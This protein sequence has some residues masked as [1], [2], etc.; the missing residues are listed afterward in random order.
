MD[1]D[2]IPMIWPVSCEA[3]TRSDRVAQAFLPSPEDLAMAQNA[4]RPRNAECL[5]TR[6]I[7]LADTS[8]KSEQQR[9]IP[10]GVSS[11]RYTVVGVFNDDDLT[12]KAIH[13]LYDAGFTVDQVSLVA[14]GTGAA[15]I[16]ASDAEAMRAT[17]GAKRGLAIGGIGG[18][19]IGALIGLGALVVPG[20][21]PVI[22]A[23]WV[24]SLLGGAAAGA[25][26]GGWIG[27]M[28]RLN[29]PEDL[30]KNYAKE[31][32]EGCCLVMVLAERGNRQS[33]AERALT[34]AGAIHVDSYPYEA[35]PGEVPG[36]E[37]VAP[38]PPRKETDQEIHDQMRP[39]M[40]V[41]GSNGGRVGTVKEIRDEDFLVDRERRTDLYVPFSVVQN[42]VMSNQTVVLAV[43]D[44]EVP[45]MGERARPG[46]PP[47]RP[48]WGMPPV[49]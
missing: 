22:T 43:P 1:V 25:A 7:A 12:E 44:Y 42:V 48:G 4:V 49:S 21:G 9:P 20:V 27:S 6:R 35:R 3:F 24:G 8:R 15:D 17:S 2:A 19:V 13:A 40:E 16:I 11:D 5:Q 31:I 41:V 10:A 32:S 26:M 36:A 29:V 30:A 38:A 46:M 39:G 45:Q 28:A 37:K 34:D 18:G 23:G 33:V 47:G 14:Q